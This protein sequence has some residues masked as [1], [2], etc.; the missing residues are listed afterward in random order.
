VGLGGP[1]W[2]YLATAYLAGHIFVLVGCPAT[3]VKKP[4]GR[5]PVRARGPHDGVMSYDEDAAEPRGASASAGD[6]R[7]AAHAGRDGDDDSGP[8]DAYSRAVMRVVAEVGPAVVS[9]TVHRSGGRGRGGEGS[10]VVIAPDG[11][12]LT[13]AHVVQGAGKLQVSFTSGSTAPARVVGQDAHTDLAVVRVEGEGL[14]HARLAGKRPI[15]V[16]QLVIAIGNPLGFSSTVSTG[17]VSALGRGLRGRDGRLMENIVQHTAPL[18][19]GNSGGPLV[20]AHCRVVGLNTAMIPHAQG[21]SFAVPASTIDWVVPKLLSDGTVKRGYLGVAG[22]A[23]PIDRRIARVHGIEQ[24][25]GVEIIEVERS[26]PGGSA[27]L[28]DGDIVLSADGD[29]TSSVDDL[30]RILSRWKQGEAL[31][32]SVLRGPKKLEIRVVPRLR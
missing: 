20:D 8:L 13:N 30:H 25:E 4:E 19:P 24:A 9:L 10:G 11:Y 12:V 1:R 32:V 5:L 28:E 16:G 2:A 27:G 3:I 7:S 21:L 14:P 22:R 15:A 31:V 6:D 18:N 29:R 26:G 23:R 17:V